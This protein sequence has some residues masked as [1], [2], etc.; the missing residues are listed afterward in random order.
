MANWRQEWGQL[1]TKGERPDGGADIV[2]S[3]QLQDGVLYRLVG[4]WV[5]SLPALPVEPS[6]EDGYI[7]LIQ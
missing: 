7:W 4:E 2:S 5:D 6:L 1:A 3:M